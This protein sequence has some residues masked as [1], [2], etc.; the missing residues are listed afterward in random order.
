MSKVLTLTHIH[1]VICIITMDETTGNSMP[2]TYFCAHFLEF[3]LDK[4]R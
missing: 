1:M 2:Q 3:S 4:K